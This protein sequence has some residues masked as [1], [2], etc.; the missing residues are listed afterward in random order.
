MRRRVSFFL[1]LL[2]LAL[3]LARL[4]VAARRQAARRALASGGNGYP[5]AELASL[6]Q[7]APEPRLWEAAG[8]AALREAHPL[9]ARAFFLRARAEGRLSAQGYGLLGDLLSEAGYLEAAQVLWERAAEVPPPEGNAWR[10]RLAQ[11][12]LRRGEWLR[13][14]TY[15]RILAREDAAY[16]CQAGKLLAVLRPEEADSYLRQAEKPGASCRAL[17]QALRENLLL[18]SLQ[19]DPAYTLTL[20]G[21]ALGRFD[22]WGLA[23]EA[24]R[25]AVERNPQ[26]AEAWA[27]LGQALERSGGDGRAALETALRLDPNSLSA[28]SLMALY[29]RA[30]GA[31]EKALVYFYRAAQAEA[32]NP[33]WE[34]EIGAT[35]AHMGRISEA[36]RHYRRA[37]QLGGDSPA[38]W[39][40]LAEFSLQ[41]N[42]DLSAIG[43][44]AARQAVLLAPKEAA[45]QELMARIYLRL[46]D[47]LTARRFARR[48]LEL[49]AGYA[50][51]Y[52]D[53]GLIASLQGDSAQARRMLETAISLAPESPWAAQARRLL[54]P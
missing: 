32:E 13:A 46:G 7:T 21:R 17:A 35:L 33:V 53:L 38:P 27:F 10:A 4:P 44:P 29:W 2:G 15:Y 49:D 25:R 40:A 50:A 43:L 54:A 36:E 18:G 47:L 48:A 11:V 23:A 16:A 30:R 14:L 22:E 52:Y 45:S 26:Y 3:A 6:A 8:R 51:A 41:Y 19:D 12:A 37:I 9:Q 24:L 20:V 1:L 39:R 28:S 5:A 42:A 31:P 34:M